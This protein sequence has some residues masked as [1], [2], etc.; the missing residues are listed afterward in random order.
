MEKTEN[1]SNY[2]YFTTP[3]DYH[4]EYYK[5]NRLTMKYKRDL[6][7]SS[8]LTQ[9]VLDWKKAKEKDLYALFPFYEGT[10]GVQDTSHNSTPSSS[11]VSAIKF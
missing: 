7:K 11:P 3:K 4:K 5:R 10:R 6:E 2:L 9:E 8:K 1:L